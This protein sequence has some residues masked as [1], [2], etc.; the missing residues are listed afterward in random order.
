MSVEFP[1]AGQR[2]AY[3]VAEVCSAAGIARATLY[4]EWKRGRGPRKLKLGKRTLI[5]RE[6][7]ADWLASLETPS[8]N[9]THEIEG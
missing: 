3:S 8:G 7:L 5:T 9:P 1:V 6:A 4:A 2:I